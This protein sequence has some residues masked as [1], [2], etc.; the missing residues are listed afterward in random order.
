VWQESETNGD[1][2]NKT[3]YKRAGIH[4]DKELILNEIW[5]LLVLLIAFL[6]MKTKYLTEETKSKKGLFF[7]WIRADGPSWWERT[8]GEKAWLLIARVGLVCSAS[9]SREGIGSRVRWWQSS[10]VSY[11]YQQSLTSWHFHNFP[12]QCFQLEIEHSNTRAYSRL[13]TFMPQCFVYTWL[14]GLWMSTLS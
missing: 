3:E 13:F 10:P 2:W 1:Q 14:L 11:F 8:Q 4:S 9:G 12:K 6:L 5:G 7:S